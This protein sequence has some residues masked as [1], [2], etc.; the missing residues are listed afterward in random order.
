MDIVRLILQR[1]E[2]RNAKNYAL[3]DE[4]RRQ[5]EVMGYRLIDG[6][7]G[8]VAERIER[9]HPKWTQHNMWAVCRDE[10]GQKWGYCSRPESRKWHE[11]MA[12]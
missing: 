1:T 11:E 5:A 12:K 4:L 8:T 7:N 2:A 3:A 6:K 9:I 10:Q